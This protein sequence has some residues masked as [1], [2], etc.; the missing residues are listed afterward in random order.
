MTAG[1]HQAYLLL[2]SNLDKERNLPAAVAL[3]RPFGLA[4]GSRGFETAPVGTRQPA[5]FL[6][7]AALVCTDLGPEAFKRDVCTAVER[8]LDRT[9]DPADKFA[10]RTIDLDLVVHDTTALDP[11]IVR[12]L[13]V[14][15]PLADLAPDLVHPVDGR[16][17]AAIADALE[18]SAD[19]AFFPVPRPDVILSVRP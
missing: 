5:R 18:A 13:H 2:G 14:A 12:Y 3:L 8:A 6:N 19:P 17:M 1:R 4:A 16:T 7:A 11:D 15:R 10:P 9:R